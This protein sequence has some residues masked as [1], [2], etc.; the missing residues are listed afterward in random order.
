VG[1][2]G[3]GLGEFRPGQST[4][5]CYPPEELPPIRVPLSGTF[6]WLRAAPEHERSIAA[7]P[8]RTAAALDCLLTS[9][10]AGLSWEFVKFFRSPALWRRIRSC[11]G[12]YLRLDSAAVG[13]R[14]GSG[15]LIRFLSD[16]QDCKH[17]HL[18]ISPCGKLHSVVATYRF[19]GSE[20][21]HLK[22]ALPHPKDI[23]TCAESF[24]E[25]VYRF[26]LE[27]E[28]WFALHDRGSMPEGGE[29]YLAFYRSRGQ[30]AE[31]SAAADPPRDIV[32]PDS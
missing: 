27:N 23:T 30:D 6:D 13:I 11:T 2:F 14:D 9:H 18:H 24:E 31:S 21:A 4:Y 1:W 32:P 16:S 12:C 19:T 10:P 28:L 26:W 8:G 17:W 15:V 29:E 7:N 3:Q 5:E 25:F 22:D 20:Q